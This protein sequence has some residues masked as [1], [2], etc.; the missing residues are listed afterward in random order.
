MKVILLYLV[1]G[2][3]VFQSISECQKAPLSFYQYIRPL[4]N[5]FCDCYVMVFKVKFHRA[6]RIGRKRKQC[7]VSLTRPQGA[8]SWICDLQLHKDST[9]EI[10]QEHLQRCD[11]RTCAFP[12]CKIYV[13][14]ET[15]KAAESYPIFSVQYSFLMKQLYNIAGRQAPS[16][17]FNRVYMF[18]S[19]SFV[20]IN[21]LHASWTLKNWVSIENFFF[22][23]FE[24]AGYSS[25]IVRA[26]N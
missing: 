11:T 4:A 10:A 15:M 26:Q 14:C 8:E 16:M 6:F 24:C 21:Q 13:L 18:L 20:N 3:L 9:K 25:S 12:R 17:T 19:R 5:V 22:S 2:K 1:L 7:Y 23:S